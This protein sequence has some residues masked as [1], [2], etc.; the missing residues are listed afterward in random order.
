MHKEIS[1]KSTEPDQNRGGSSASFLPNDSP[2]F[3][4]VKGCSTKPKPKTETYIYQN[5]PNRS[6]ISN[7]TISHKHQSTNTQFPTRFHFQLQQESKRNDINIQTTINDNILYTRCIRND[8]KHSIISTPEI[9]KSI[10]RI[11]K[12]HSGKKRQLEENEIHG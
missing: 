10:E 3:S 5:N 1:F 11:A 9:E 7:I 2:H 6:S 4:S 8:R 12:L